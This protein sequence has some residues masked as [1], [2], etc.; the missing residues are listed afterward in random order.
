MIESFRVLLNKS[1]IKTVKYDSQ[2]SKM[3]AETVKFHG[4]VT[5]CFMVQ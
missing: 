2:P 1:K 5:A 3:I 4:S